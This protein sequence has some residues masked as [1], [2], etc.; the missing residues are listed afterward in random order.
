M[1]KWDLAL[2]LRY[3]GRNGDGTKDQYIAGGLSIE[4]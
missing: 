2:T 3:E 1:P 4:F